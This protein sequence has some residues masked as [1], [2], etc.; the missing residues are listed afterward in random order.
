[1]TNFT[2]SEF[3]RLSTFGALG[4]VTTRGFALS[5]VF[6]FRTPM[7]DGTKTARHQRS[8][9]RPGLGNAPPHPPRPVIARH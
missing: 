6:R 3:L 7:P 2:R 8:R 5:D 9:Q 1:M 4:L